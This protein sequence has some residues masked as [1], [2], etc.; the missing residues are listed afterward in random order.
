[1]GEGRENTVL[2]IAPKV[3]EGFS[4]RVSRHTLKLPA[5]GGL[6]PLTPQ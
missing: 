2:G 6:P 3:I 1:M 5:Q 4:L